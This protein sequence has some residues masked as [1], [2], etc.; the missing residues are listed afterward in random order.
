MVLCCIFVLLYVFV[1][2]ALSL[3]TTRL[4]IKC[5]IKKINELLHSCFW[6]IPLP[7]NFMFRRFGTSYLVHLQ[8]LF[9]PPTKIEET[10]CSETSSHK[11]QTPGNHPKERI[12]HSGHD[13]SLESRIELVWIEFLLH[14][15]GFLVYT[16]QFLLNRT[17]LPIL[18]NTMIWTYCS[19]I[20]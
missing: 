9:T 4:L 20:Y 3:F 10:E 6:V 18:L 2:Y 8:R 14:I 5:L 15:I 13:E 7:L 19:I 1:R 12:Q 11:I 17:S 16:L